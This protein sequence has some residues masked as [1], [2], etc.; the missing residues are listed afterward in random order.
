[1]KGIVYLIGAGPGDAGL[2][3]K[4][5]LDYLKSSD[6]VV[7]DRLVNKDLLDYTKEGAKFIYVGKT[8]KH[9]TKTQDEINEI[10]YQEALAGNK[11]ARLK[12]GDPYVFGR[13]GE[14]GEYLYDRGIEFVEVPGVTSAIGGL[15][16]AGIPITHRGVATS[17][18]VITGH[19]QDG[20]D[21][22]NWEALANIKGTLVFLMGVGNLERIKD[23]L[24]ENGKDPKTRAALVNWG[25][26]T[27]QRVVEGNLEDIYEIALEAKITPPSLIVVGD[28]VKLREKL[29]FHE[30]KPL[31]GKNIVI[32]REKKAAKST[33]KKLKELGANVLSFPSIKIEEV[34]NKDEIE[35]EIK[36]LSNYNYLVFTSVNGVDIFFNDLFNAG[37][38]SRSL[39]Q[40]Q[41][42]VVG[43]KTGDAL[44]KYGVRADYMPDKYVGE[45][46]LEL[47]KRIVKKD[48]KVLM[49]RAK[50][51]RDLLMDELEKVCEIKE[52]IIYDTVIDKSDKENIKNSLKVLD[53][54]YILFTSSSTVDNFI[55][56]LGDEDRDLL[57]KAKIVSIGPITSS[58]VAEND[59]KLD[60]EAEDY[61]I[62]GVI[63]AL[64]KEGN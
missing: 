64:I 29:M 31:F 36:N 54:Y 21:D 58:T 60:I 53:D 61:T 37:L 5:G 17:F 56:I 14:E 40:I 47:L 25:T 19:L 46:L 11:V 35:R 27:K 8:A 34:D 18:H 52:L 13:G 3:T 23:K 10:I 50:I 15:A 33:I 1:M 49:P 39:G 28:V 59:L 42:V 41:T 32:T 20:S 55:K 7:Y 26:T 44:K 4:K 48:D 12:G 16:Y 57:E 2:I 30:R 63:E 6:V 43:P 62:D 51:A 45:D 22:L 24:I 9:H 38:D